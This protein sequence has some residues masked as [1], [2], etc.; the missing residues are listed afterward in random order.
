M[1]LS[2]TGIVGNF[3]RWK[4]HEVGVLKMKVTWNG[5]VRGASEFREGFLLIG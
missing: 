1:G 3:G 4:R 2:A 5:V